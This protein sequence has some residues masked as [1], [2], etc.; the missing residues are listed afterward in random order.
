M[1]WPMGVTA[2]YRKAPAMGTQLYDGG[3]WRNANR[4]P[5]PRPAF[6]VSSILAEET[7]LARRT[8]ESL[9]EHDDDEQDVELV[10][11]RRRASASKNG[12]GEMAL[13]HGTRDGQR[14]TDDN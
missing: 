10:L 3:S 4:A 8:L 6:E 13:A 9:M 12:I 5:R 2:E 7:A 11:S 1:A 14:Q